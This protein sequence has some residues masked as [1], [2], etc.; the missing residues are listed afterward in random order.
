MTET[1]EATYHNLLQQLQKTDPLYDL[2]RLLIADLGEV[3]DVVIPEAIQ[4]VLDS[5]GA[6]A[7]LVEPPLFFT[8]SVQPR[9]VRFNWED[10]GIPND[11]NI[12]EYEL[13]KGTVWEAATFQVRTNSTQVD[14]NPIATGTHRF[15]LKSINA[16]GIYSVHVA[17]LD[18]IINA[19]GNVS[20]SAVVIDNNVNLSWTIPTSP[21]TLDYY[22]IKSAKSPAALVERA[23]LSGNFFSKFETSEGTYIYSITPVDIA[24]NL[25]PEIQTTTDVNQPPDFA[26]Q[27]S[28][29]SAFAG[30]KVNCLLQ[31]NGRLLACIDTTETWHDHF[32]DRSWNSIADQ[33][34]AG[35]NLY[36][37]PSLLTGYYEE[38]IDYGA[39]FNNL[40]VNLDYSFNTIIGTVAVQIQIAGSDDGISYTAFQTG[41]SAFF[42]SLRYAKIKLNFTPVD[43]ESLIEIFNLK[44]T[45]DVK[46]E[47]DSG[48]VD[49]DA[50]DVNGTE[51][52]FN[53]AF[54][55][56]D[57]IVCE[58][59]S[60]EPVSFVIDFVD[61][62]NPTSFKL[63]V[64][65]SA[66][67]RISYLAYWVARGIV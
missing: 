2:I 51:V 60:L 23:R 43:D 6:P 55:D 48:E 13:R 10:L 50:A 25:G 11:I 27:A 64:F 44:I 3:R 34:A 4:S 45:L 49:A 53:K 47:V 30:T 19:I 37:L 36:A 17:E 12:K 54:K 59:Q 7:P 5:L 67:I 16:D 40:I 8:Y 15:L 9:S 58:N 63:L 1:R 33:V 42:S 26:L 46:R 29:I 57:S 52:F 20:V 56:I 14:I 38:V 35:Y 62:P 28:F 21:F 32:F 22:I 66:G 18:V 61:A 39:I 65:D 24:G 41:N 31:S